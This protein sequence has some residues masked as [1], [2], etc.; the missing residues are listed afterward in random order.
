MYSSGDEIE[1]VPI[2]KTFLGTMQDE[3]LLLQ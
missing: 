1:A 2:S 3:W